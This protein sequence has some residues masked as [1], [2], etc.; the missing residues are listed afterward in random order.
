MRQR[1]IMYQ[2]GEVEALEDLFVEQEVLVPLMF[3]PL[4]RKYVV[5]AVTLTKTWE[6]VA[7][8]VSGSF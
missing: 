2:G 1:L 5:K 8:T 4:S 3:R 7:R 6:Y